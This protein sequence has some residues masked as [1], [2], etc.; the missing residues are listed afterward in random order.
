MQPWFF[1]IG[2]FHL[3]CRLWVCQNAIT[4]QGQYL[5]NT[6]KSISSS[7]HYV[8]LQNNLSQPSLVIYFFPTSPLKIKTGTAK[9][10]EA[11]TNSVLWIA[12]PKEMQ[13]VE[14]HGWVYP[15]PACCSPIE[16]IIESLRCIDEETWLSQNKRSPETLREMKHSCFH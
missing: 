11:W 6:P 8:T 3:G 10:W 12:C 15:T 13:F 16:Y 7:A 4:R 9:R 1:S 14:F 2:R 5:F